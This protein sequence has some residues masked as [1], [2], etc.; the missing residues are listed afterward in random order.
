MEFLCLCGLS[1]LSADLSDVRRWWN[2]VRTPLSL[3]VSQL[4]GEGFKTFLYLSKGRKV[5]LV[6][7]V[8][9]L[10]ARTEDDSVFNSLAEWLAPLMPGVRLISGNWRAL[11]L[12]CHE[13][14]EPSSFLSSIGWCIQGR[15]L[16][17]LFLLSH[18]C[19]SQERHIQVQTHTQT[20][21]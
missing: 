7:S 16:R 19:A 12:E 9:V 18:L 13:W 6:C 10:V 21:T 15:C 1:R 8:W 3:G 2:G 14:Q 5:G 17:C 20:H 11:H 4:K